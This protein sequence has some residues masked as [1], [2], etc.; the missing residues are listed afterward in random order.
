M[1]PVNDYH[2]LIIKNQKIPIDQWNEF[3]II[4]ERLLVDPG[5]DLPSKPVLSLDQKT[6]E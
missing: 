4:K 6:R 3:L 2:L 1:N 5:R